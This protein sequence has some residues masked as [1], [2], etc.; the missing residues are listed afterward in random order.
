[1]LC[2]SS[3]DLKVLL[4]SL[5]SKKQMDQLSDIYNEFMMHSA[6]RSS[7]KR[8]SRKRSDFSTPKTKSRLEFASPHT[9]HANLDNLLDYLDSMN[10]STWRRGIGRD[11]PA[12]KDGLTIDDFKS[13]LDSIC[14]QH[15]LEN[16]PKVFK[17]FN[18]LKSAMPHHLPQFLT[19]IL[20]HVIPYDCL[21][22]DY[23]H[24]LKDFL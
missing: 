3:L 20:Y 21:A 15:S 16:A 13:V 22:Q 6:Q 18:L 12:K 17:A 14:S 9:E 4:S 7:R 8:S 11:T 2:G 1:M 5:N 23:H 24:Q 19:S 10:K